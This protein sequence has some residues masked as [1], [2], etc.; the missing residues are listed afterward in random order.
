MEGFLGVVINDGLGVFF[1]CV[2]VFFGARGRSVICE[3]I[4]I[5][6][7]FLYYCNILEF[8]CKRMRNLFIW[9]FTFCIAIEAQ[10]FCAHARSRRLQGADEEQALGFTTSTLNGQWLRLRK[11]QRSPS[12]LH[13]YQYGW[14]QPRIGKV[15]AVRAEGGNAFG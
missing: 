15:G 1:L 9:C 6:V 12:S 7:V 13:N 10:G 11:G 8:F 4:L 14:E 2:C 5:L 3:G